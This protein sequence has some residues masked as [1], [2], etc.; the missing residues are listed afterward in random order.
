MRRITPTLC[1]CLTVLAVLLAGSCSRAVSSRSAFPSQS[2]TPTSKPAESSSLPPPTGITADSMPV[3]IAV[4]WESPMGPEPDRITVTASVSG[5]EPVVSLT[6]LFT[7]TGLDSRI[8][9]FDFASCSPSHPILPDAAGN[10]SI[11]LAG[12]NGPTNLESHPVWV[13]GTL[14]NGA[15]FAYSTRVDIIHNSPHLVIPTQS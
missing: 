11:T 4:L 3:G 14:Q 9:E 13:S 2:S 10:D 8:F 7:A 1:T 15:I 6:V 5:D 12:S